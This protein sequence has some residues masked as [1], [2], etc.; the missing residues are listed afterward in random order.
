MAYKYMKVFIGNNMLEKIKSIFD[1]CAIGFTY[2]PPLTGFEI[3]DPTAW[4]Q[5]QESRKFGEHVSANKELY[6]SEIKWC[7]IAFSLY[8]LV[9]ICCI[10]AAVITAL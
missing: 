7:R 5:L 2:S 3:S 8:L 10:V 9:I 4:D 1:S 6:S